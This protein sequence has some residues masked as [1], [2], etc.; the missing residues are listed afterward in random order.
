VDAGGGFRRDA[1]S[2]KEVGPHDAEGPR[3]S[4]R[5][6]RFIKSRAMFTFVGGVLVI[7]PAF[8]QDAQAPQP[9]PAQ[10]AQPAA[11]QARELDTIVVTGIRNSLEQSMG[12]KRDTPG[13]VD[14]ISAE[15]IGKFP[16]TNLAESLQRITGISIERRNGEGAQVTARGFGPDFNMVTLNGRQI[17]GADGFSNGDQVTG[18]VGSGSRGFNFSQLASESISGITVFKTG[19]ANAPSGGIG[20]TLDILTARPFDRTGTVANAGAKIVSDRSQVFGSDITPE[21]SGIFSHTNAD[22]TWGISL[23]GSYQKRNSG[24]VQATENQWNIRRWTGS[25]NAF[26]SDVNIVNAPAIGSLYT[27]PNDLRYAFSDVERERVNGQAVLQFAPT[28]A[29]TFTL[30]YTYSSNEIAENRGEQTM[31]LNQGGGFTDIEFDTSGAVAVPVYLREVTGSKDFGYEQQRNMQKFRLDSIGFNADW[32]VNDRFT[33]TFYAHNTLSRSLPNDPITGGSATF[34]S[35]A[36]TNATGDSRNCTGA[37]CGGN[38]TQEF[39][40][41]NG[42]PV[43]TRTWFP[44]QAAALA[45]TG[46]VVNPDFPPGQLGSQVRRIWHT[47]QETEVTQG[48]IDGVLEFDEGRFQ[49]GV[50]S[51]KV[52]MKRQNSNDS[53]AALGDWS[54]NNV[55]NEPGMIALLNP[56]SIAGL[57]SDYNTTGI[58]PG[59][60]WGNASELAAWAEGAYGVPATYNAALTND[61]RIEEKTDAAYV[62][63]IMD[64]E[65]GGMRTNT[66]IGLRYERTD[67]VSTSQIVVPEAIEW[68]DDNDFRIAQS[69]EVQPFSETGRYSY[70]L[71]NV[72]FSIDFTSE[73][74]GRASYSQTIARPGYGNL[75]AGPTANNPTGS[76]LVAE[77][78]RASGDAQ[79]PALEPLESNNLDLALE[80][81]FAPSSFVSVTYWNK[82]V[83]NFIG[84]TQIREN[85]Y[86]LRDPTSGPDAQAVLAFLQSAQCVAQVTAAGNDPNV[87][88]ANNVALFTG[89]AMF[90]NP[91]TGGLAAYNGSDAQWQAIATAYDII[92][93]PDD[94]L[95]QFNV[96]RPV[97][98]REAKIHGWEIGGQYFFGDSGFGLAANYTIVNGNIGIDDAADPAAGD[99]FALTGLSDTAN[100]VLMYEKYGWTARL[101]WNWRDKYLIAANQNG[102]NRNPYYVEAY[103]Q[104]DLSVGYTFNDQWAIGFEAINLTGE[105]IRW[106]SRTDKMMVKLLDQSP[107]Y[108]LGVRYRF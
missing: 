55:G 105:D 61:N 107:R 70:L 66:V 19:R 60:W 86:G 82:R 53:Y 73:L 24:D 8:A 97:N 50:D 71:P 101:A 13:V 108:M 45:G 95:Y 20:A 96:N 2:G 30:D 7:N 47:K 94:P 39:F 65:L 6:M 64:G 54:V 9:A 100:L 56:I 93:E 32:A 15:D 27:I 76:I 92:G 84:T 89:L 49:F 43:A 99:Q 21:V 69:S 28:D 63:W 42:L 23:S 38:W 67:V 40:F 26:R 29:L 44:S 14:A 79:N 80:W 104:L 72:D 31:W 102:S 11:Q 98:Q 25:D 57:F 106:H 16:D 10:Q 81:Y 12:T 68:Q 74:K 103:D 77:S 87:C 41:N 90:R 78:M 33:L 37:Y 17:P 52:T 34:F 18:G 22:K 35:L 85:L 51:S 3:M 59:A 1:R 46:G 4:R 75:Y 58:A 62:Q 36:G 88:S 5:S 91:E 48:R 83:N